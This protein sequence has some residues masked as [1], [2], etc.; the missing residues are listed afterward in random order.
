MGK[1]PFHI[2]DKKVAWCVNS[3][4]GNCNNLGMI[5]TGNMQ[6]S[7]PAPRILSPTR[8]SIHLLLKCSLFSDGTGV[9]IQRR[10]GHSTPP[11]QFGG[12]GCDTL[13]Q[14]TILRRILAKR[15]A[16]EGLLEIW[17][18]AG[19]N[20]HVPHGKRNSIH[21]PC[22]WASVCSL[23]T[24]DIKAELG[25]LQHTEEILN[26]VCTPMPCHVLGCSQ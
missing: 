22:L 6:Q 13:T 16:S 7:H 26:T 24:Q 18:I 19:G 8:I 14:C 21:S 25:I 17:L 3:L 1:P 10:R 4:P 11:K 5:P 9:R 20:T 2:V 15:T 12:S 23:I